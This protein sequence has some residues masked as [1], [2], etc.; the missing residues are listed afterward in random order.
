MFDHIAITFDLPAQELSNVEGSFYLKNGKILL[1]LP[2]DGSIPGYIQRLE[3]RIKKNG[4]SCLFL[5]CQL[6]AFGDHFNE[7]AVAETYLNQE[8]NS[9]DHNTYI[10]CRFELTG[11]ILPF[12]NQ[13]WEYGSNNT[14]EKR[15]TLVFRSQTE[16]S[17]EIKL[18]D[19]ATL[20]IKSGY[21]QQYSKIRYSVDSSVIFEFAFHR[22]A[23]RQEAFRLAEAIAS[24]YG[25]FCYEPVRVR[26]INLMVDSVNLIGYFGKHVTQDDG[27]ASLG[28]TVIEQSS[29]K[30]YVD[31]PLISWVCDY[32]R[33]VIPAAL[34][35]DAQQVQEETLRF[36][37][38]TRALEV[39]HKKFFVEKPAREYLE[40]LH[41]FLSHYQFI[42]AEQA[43]K[44]G[45]Q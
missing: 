2:V 30:D 11:N 34:L 44:K 43:C 8:P 18:N 42:M 37:C 13:P 33:Y 4:Q 14:V 41:A 7:Y 3:A 35:R 38:L 40:G 25:I 16:R 28:A 36:I 9:F 15:Q 45:V 32:S 31:E 27:Q 21:T 5:T 12:F 22:T 26:A 10:N 19:D 1:V 17:H 24:Y 29:I 6:I 20:I 39:F 23:T